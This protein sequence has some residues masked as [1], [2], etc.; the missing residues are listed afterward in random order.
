MDST[1]RL[2]LQLFC[3]IY[4]NPISYKSCQGICW[5]PFHLWHLHI[6]EMQKSTC[7][8]LRWDFEDTAI[9]LAFSK[10]GLSSNLGSQKWGCIE[11][12]RDLKASSGQNRHLNLISY[13]LVFGKTKTKT[14]TNTSQRENNLIKM[15]FSQAFSD[16]ENRWPRLTWVFFW[17]PPTAET[18]LSSATAASQDSLL[19][20]H[21]P[22]AFCLFLL[23]THL[24]LFHRRNQGYMCVMEQVQH[25]PMSPPLAPHT[26]RLSAC[27]SNEWSAPQIAS[28]VRLSFWEKKNRLHYI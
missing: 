20:W 26:T 5:R 19:T 28:V 8:C 27:C 24:I 18:S 9:A 23:V 2:L 12:K 11:A 22:A 7:D 25:H 1:C 21:H 15:I 10:T 13:R 3:K 6:C 4:R 16:R 14:E 17:L